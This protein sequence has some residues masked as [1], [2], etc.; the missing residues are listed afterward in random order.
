MKPNQLSVA[1]M[2]CG[3]FIFLAAATCLVANTLFHPINTM[4]TPTALCFISI[5]FTKFALA[6]WLRKKL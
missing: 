4:S 3:G 6:D 5:A 1:M 2:L